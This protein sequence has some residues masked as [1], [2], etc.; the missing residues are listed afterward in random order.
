MAMEPDPEPEQP[1]RELTAAEKAQRSAARQQAEADAAAAEALRIHG[2][3][4]GVEKEKW[5]KIRD[6]AA[7]KDAVFTKARNARSADAKW[8]E[9]KRAAQKA[10]AMAERRAAYDAERRKGNGRVYRAEPRFDVD[11]PEARANVA[12]AEERAAL[13]HAEE[14]EAAREL[15]HWKQELRH[16]TAM[17]AEFR[18]NAELK[19]EEASKLAEQRCG[20][21]VTRPDRAY[22][23]FA[24]GEFDSP[25]CLEA[26][27]A[28]QTELHDGLV[29][30]VDGVPQANRDIDARAVALEQEVEQLRLD[31]RPIIDE[32]QQIDPQVRG[33][34]LQMAKLGSKVEALD[35]AADRKA[36]EGLDIRKQQA[37]LWDD[38]PGKKAEAEAAGLAL[39][40]LQQEREEL[41]AA[42]KE[43][44]ELIADWERKACDY[45]ETARD[46]V[47]KATVRKRDANKEGRHAREVLRKAQLVY[48]QLYERTEEFQTELAK[49]RAHYE[50]TMAAQA[51]K[52]AAEQAEK[53]RIAE[54]RRLAAERK[55]KYEAACQAEF[56]AEQAERTAKKQQE[57]LA[58]RAARRFFDLG[59][60]AK[61]IVTGGS[62]CGA[63]A[64]VLNIRATFG[65][66][67]SD[68]YLPGMRLAVGTPDS[69][70]VIW[71]TF[72]QV[73]PF[74]LHT[75]AEIRE[76]GHG[77]VLAVNPAL[78]GNYPHGGGKT[79]R[80]D[81]QLIRSRS[82]GAMRRHGHKGAD[83]W[84]APT[85]A[86]RKG[87]PA[88][89]PGLR[90][91]GHVFYPVPHSAD[92][93]DEE[94]EEAEQARTAA[95][96][97]Q[98]A[99]EMQL[100]KGRD[101]IASSL[102]VLEGARP[103]GSHSP[104][105][106]WSAATTSD[107]SPTKLKQGHIASVL[108]RR[109]TSAAAVLVAPSQSRSG[110]GATALCGIGARQHRSQHRTGSGA[111]DGW[112]RP[113]SATA[114]LFG[115][116]SPTRSISGGTREAYWM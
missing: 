33:N 30:W 80:L 96:A 19:C 47:E 94:R 18:Q 63:L 4:S 31:T 67:N 29:A 104:P 34:A 22:A 56:E 64:T 38:L 101:A 74:V 86:T 42:E 106:V 35:L 8:R 58:E 105:R 49:R 36:Q 28:K 103:A 21:T 102:Q 93:L 3:M 112:S 100:Q 9:E 25:W 37:K 87:P 68:E 99:L 46:A 15:E 72:D 45:T 65:R 89:A 48:Q 71:R 43:A 5:R 53:E 84:S 82:A 24:R 91:P 40:A 109:P 60:F 107:A 116:V 75:D 85:L 6:E 115:V 50:E 26:R 57:M 70:I 2:E 88:S 23:S 52:A 10:R 44:G 1:E 16:A 108:H 77:Y 114:A 17:T 98:L 51:A 110:A 59:K 113:K 81:N 111:L 7:A 78:D 62:Y 76:R 79:R 12:A 55:A 54:E 11:L 95:L 83:G 73:E 32:I 66:K 61:V 27:I 14:E 41:M 69:G 97:T 92:P 20:I 13:A 39:A 90:R